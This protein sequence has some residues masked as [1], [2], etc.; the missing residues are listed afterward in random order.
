MI[1]L[2]SIL[3]IRDIILPTKVHLVKAMIF[4]VVIYR[5]ESWTVKETKLKEL[6]LSNNGA[7]EDS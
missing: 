1:N 2:E 4:P 5:C 6:V 7:R 3:K